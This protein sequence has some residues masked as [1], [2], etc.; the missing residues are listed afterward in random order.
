MRLAKNPF[1]KNQ[2]NTNLKQN[3]E[4]EQVEEVKIDQE[5]E[6][7]HKLP[8]YVVNI[9]EKNQI[10]TNLKQNKEAEQVEEVKIDQEK[11]KEHKLPSYVV[12]ITEKK[13]KI[14]SISRKII[15]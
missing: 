6:K 8:S 5:K 10:N 1:N 4:A 13:P 7:E 11:K 12:N 15:E 2:I 3:K 9:T 14:F